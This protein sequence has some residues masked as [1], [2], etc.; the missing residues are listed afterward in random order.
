MAAQTGPAA[1]TLGGPE[2]GGL[3]FSLQHGHIC[4]LRRVDWDKRLPAG[5]KELDPCPYRPCSNK[6]LLGALAGGI[7]QILAGAVEAAREAFF[8]DASLIPFD[9]YQPRSNLAD[10][11]GVIAILFGLV[12]VDALQLHAIGQAQRAVLAVYRF[13]LA[14]QHRAV[15]DKAGDKAVHRLLIQRLDAID[16]LN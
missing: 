11:A 14:F 16:L 9:P 15:A 1:I 12:D 10:P 3:R 7:V 4:H 8:N 6:T 13:N 5:Q 2:E